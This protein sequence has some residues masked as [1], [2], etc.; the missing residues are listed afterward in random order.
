GR[1]VERDLELVRGVA[2]GGRIVVAGIEV[3]ARRGRAVWRRHLEQVVPVVDGRG[4]GRRAGRERIDGAVGDLAGGGDLLPLPAAVVAVPLIR[5]VEL[6]QGPGEAGPGGELAVGADVDD[7]E[8]GLG[9]RLQPV[10]RGELRLDADAVGGRGDRT[11]ERALDRAAVGIDEAHDH[12][13]LE[14]PRRR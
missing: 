5:R 10:A 13:G 1:L 4:D 14:R 12:V 7:V 8:A 9:A 6:A 11:G 3:V 2:T